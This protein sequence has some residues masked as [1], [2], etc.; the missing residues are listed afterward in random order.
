VLKLGLLSL[1]ACAALVRAETGYDAWLRYAPLEGAALEQYRL[2]VPA[3]VAVPDP[4]P[5]AMSARAEIVRG[6]KGMLGRAHPAGGVERAEEEC[7]RDG[8]GGARSRCLLAQVRDTRGAAFH[9][10][11]RFRRSRTALRRVRA[12]AQNHVGREPGESRSA[13]DSV[14]A[15][16]TVRN[17]SEPTPGRGDGPPMVT[18]VEDA[19]GGKVVTCAG[20]KSC[21]ASTKFSG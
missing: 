15:G 20:A 7:H 4:S 9:R 18:P 1:L 21:T 14:R 19:S 13:R 5:L 17:I 2:A 11:R 8:N 12:A 10:H 16:Y 3:V 6:V